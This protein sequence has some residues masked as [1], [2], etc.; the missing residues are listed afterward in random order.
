MEKYTCYDCML[1]RNG[2]C[3]GGKEICK[4]FKFAPSLKTEDK[5]Y[6]PRVMGS[7]RFA[8]KIEK[9]EEQERIKKN[10][11]KNQAEKREPEKKSISKSASTPIHH[12]VGRPIIKYISKATSKLLSE[13]EVKQNNDKENSRVSFLR[14]G[15]ENEEISKRIIESKD[16]YWIMLDSENKKNVDRGVLIY[17]NFIKSFYFDRGRQEDSNFL[18][19]EITSIMKKIKYRNTV[20]NTIV[21]KNEEFDFR[22]IKMIQD[23]YNHQQLIGNIYLIRVGRISID[24]IIRLTGIDFK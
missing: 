11:V 3:F 4:D 8:G 14:K 1:C 21:A 17:N 13:N 2:E 15:R 19:H 22:E 6:F 20:I 9:K 24:E 18:V 16:E 5:E 7:S 10:I 12:P 23:F